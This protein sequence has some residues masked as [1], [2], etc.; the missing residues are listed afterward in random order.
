ELAEG[1][2]GALGLVERVGLALVEDVG[3]V[4]VGQV[5]DELEPGGRVPGD[6]GGEGDGGRLGQ[7]AA[8]EH[9][10]GGVAV[11]AMEVAPLVVGD[12]AEVDVAA[13]AVLGPLRGVERVAGVAGGRRVARVAVEAG[14]VVP[15][16]APARAPLPARAAD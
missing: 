9:R 16:A 5:S 3:V 7:V 15:A 13:G 12:E 4:E 8:V 1:V 11:D 6:L 10:A 14:G 2:L